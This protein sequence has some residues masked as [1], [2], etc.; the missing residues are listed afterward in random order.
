MVACKVCGAHF[1]LAPPA[2]LF[3]DE[4]VDERASRVG[5][6]PVCGSMRAYEGGDFFAVPAA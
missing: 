1:D 2:P 3:A 5:A 6:C 4:A